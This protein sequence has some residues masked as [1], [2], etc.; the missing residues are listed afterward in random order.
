MSETTT[1]A[2]ESVEGLLGKKLAMSQ[3]FTE[4]GR[5]IPVTVIECGPCVVL[6][7]K[8]ESSDGYRALQLGFGAK[9]DKRVKK[10][11]LGHFKKVGAESKAFIREVEYRGEEPPA[12]PGAQLTL[13][14]FEAGVKVDV[15][16]TSKGR[17]FAGTIKRHG[18]ARGPMTHGSHNKRR[19]GS[20][21]CAAD[22][23]RVFKGTRGPGRY[24]GKQI[25]VQ[26]LEVVVVDAERN[27][28]MVRGAIP[29]PAGGYVVI[30]KARWS[31]S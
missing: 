20:I 18:F 11:Q 31:N 29:G 25:T 30:R 7:V 19:P 4:D 27:L 6:Q 22:P 17:G 26:N 28:L 14:M 8:T 9:R 21:G 12:E 24:G 1:V 23:A 2:H 3:I 16:G 10:P 5:A 13:E 15:V